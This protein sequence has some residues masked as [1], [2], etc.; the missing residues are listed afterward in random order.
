VAAPHHVVERGG[1]APVAAPAPAAP[2]AA[3][4]AAPAPADSPDPQAPD[5]APE[6]PAEVPSVAGTVVHVSHGGKAFVLATEAGQLIAV[7]S[8]DAAPTLGDKLKVTV[9]ALDDGTFRE[10]ERKV[11]GASANARFH[12]VVTFA[13]PAARTYTVSARGT[14]M[15][16]SMPPPADGAPPPPTPA[17]GTSVTVEASFPDGPQ[18]HLQ[19]VKREDGDPAAGDLDLEAIVRDP[20]PAAPDR[21]V[22]S[23]DDAGE[24]PGTLSLTVP[25]E[26][27][28]SKL[29]V[30]G[31]VIAAT[32]KLEADGS[33]TLVSAAED[34]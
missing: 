30:P 32:V 11:K 1:G 10:R 7:H 25:P 9:R 34:R 13:D 28:V 6:A 5:P 31:T 3:A 22:V 19:E 17:V 14:S 4:P 20:D 24:S 21:L 33:L 18:P 8:T 16:V 2:A 23:A 12:G 29:R 15:L 26:L 27:D